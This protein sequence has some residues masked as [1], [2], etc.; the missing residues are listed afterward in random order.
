MMLP[1]KIKKQKLNW[2]KVQQYIIMPYFVVGSNMDNYGT[3]YLS[4]IHHMDFVLIQ[5]EDV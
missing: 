5:L 3:E 2:R 1:K 4:S